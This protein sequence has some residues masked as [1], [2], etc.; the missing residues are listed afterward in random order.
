MSYASQVLPTMRSTTFILD[1]FILSTIAISVAS[2][3]SSPSASEQDISTADFQVPG[4]SVRDFDQS[5]VKS[6]ETSPQHRD[7]VFPEK[8]YLRSSASEQDL[9][10]SKE[11]A[12]FDDVAHGKESL[13]ALSG[14]SSSSDAEAAASLK[15][16]FLRSSAS[17][18]D[19]LASRRLSD[20]ECGTLVEHCDD[21]ETRSQCEQ[22][23]K[24]DDGDY[25]TCY[26][27]GNRC[28]FSQ[29]NAEICSAKCETLV[30]HC[31]D[32]KT[33][34]QC[35][36]SYKFDG[37]DYLTCSWNGN[38]CKF[39]QGNAEPCIDGGPP[40]APRPTRRPTPRPTRRP[41][42]R[43]NP[44]PTR[45]PTPRPTRR[46]TPR[47]NPQSTRRPTPRPTRRPTPWPTPSPGG[48]GTSRS[49]GGGTSRSGG[50]T[51]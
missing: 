22:S 18:Q 45:R 42:P 47:P 15:D 19:L 23:Y 39:S 36:Q 12:Q 7:K 27:N 34:S 20:H 50:G 4:I 24:F 31:S 43:P 10:K 26:W 5:Q 49:G 1:T 51:N 38:R 6:S 40:S 25:L 14:D 16:R 46:P 11:S 8:R 29:G 2:I 48:G 37:G 9:V 17:A 13:V 28:K 21:A 32:S 44:Q 33:R 30:E 3:G 41:T 35:E